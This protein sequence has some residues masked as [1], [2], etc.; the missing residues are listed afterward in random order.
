MDSLE[1]NLFSTQSKLQYIN[2][3]LVIIMASFLFACSNSEDASSIATGSQDGSGITIPSVILATNL[4]NGSVR[5]F[6]TVDGVLPRLEMDLSSDPA[7]IT[8]PNLVPGLHTFKIEFEFDSDPTAFNAT[9]MLADATK[10]FDIVAG[11]NNISF[12]D[13]DYNLVFDNDADGITNIAELEAGT[14]PGNAACIL[15]YSLLD[16]CVLG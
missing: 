14:N 5:G 13:A 7:T 2:I 11:E 4:P 6:I 1:I 9:F 10:Q 8:I 12:L 3:M 15:D 16:S